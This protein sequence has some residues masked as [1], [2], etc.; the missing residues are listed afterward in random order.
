VADPRNRLDQMIKVLKGKGHRLTPQRLAVL[1]ILAKS[2]GHPS[3]ETVF[4][5]VKA[6]F[7]T[8]SLA[9]VYNT[10]NLLKAAHEVLELGFPN[11]GSRYDGNKPYSHPHA[12]CT[13]CGE[14][15]DPACDSL[16]GLTREMAGQ[17]GFHITHYQ[18]YFFG[19]C[20]RCQRKN[21]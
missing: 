14:I 11:L 1:K 8:T 19:L 2:E 17:T 3:V 12:I 13:G 15:V 9:T 6:T 21:K 4:E 16:E 5:K 18:M 10:V 20:P 7:P